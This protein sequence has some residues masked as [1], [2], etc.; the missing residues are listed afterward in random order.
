MTTALRAAALAAGLALA[1]VAQAQDAPPPGCRWMGET[2]ACKDGKGHWVRSG[3]GEV[4]GTYPL[5]KPKPKPAPAAVAPRPAAA[6]KAVAPPTTGPFAAELTP[7]PPPPPP[8][9]EEMSPPPAVPPPE[10]VPSVPVATPAA[11]E[12][13][14]TVAPA[15]VTGQPEKPKSWWRRWLDDIW[16]DIQALL[17][18]VGIGR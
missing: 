17:R 12:P 15:E 11:A 2:L 10:A 4:V 6:A 16:S 13:A 18:L 5:S 1:G 14:P 8:P 3:D 7:P 9:P